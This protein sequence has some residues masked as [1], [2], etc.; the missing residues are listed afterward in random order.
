MK[1]KENKKYQRI[2]Y[3]HL[4]KYSPYKKNKSW[5]LWY[6]HVAVYKG[7][8]TVKI[9]KEYKNTDAKVLDLG[10][11]IGLTLAILS[12]NFP[13]I[14]GCD[15]E[16]Y[17]V[18]TSKELLKKT[19]KVVPI[20][21]YNGKKL[22]FKD[23]S[24]DIVTL[25]EVYEHVKDPKLLIDE[26]HRVL[27]KDGLLHITT[28]NKWWPIEPHYKLLFLSYLPSFLSDM[29]VRLSGRGDRYSDIKLPGYGEFKKVVGRRFN[30]EDIT[31]KLIENYEKYAFHK[32]RGMKILIVGEFL[33]ILRLLEKIPIAGTLAY[34][35][36]QFLLRISLGWLFIGREKLK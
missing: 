13:N 28:A 23:N 30:V 6:S 3:E 24:F 11:G 18:E 35:F 29:Y 10:C 36:K 34:L 5:T 15:T 26:V 19:N 16:K 14:V 25:I 32:E 2:F 7:E 8:R 27:R 33:K 22:P 17:A 31:L 9:L 21:L 1:K 4:K 20:Y 12:D